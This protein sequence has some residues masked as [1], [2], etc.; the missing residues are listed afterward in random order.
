MIYYTDKFIRVKLFFGYFY[1]VLKV[2]VLVL[3]GQPAALLPVNQLTGCVKHAR[4]TSKKSTVLFIGSVQRLIL[5][6]SIFL[7][8]G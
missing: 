1:P 3:S 6:M 4:E 2:L 7:T 5:F 8:T